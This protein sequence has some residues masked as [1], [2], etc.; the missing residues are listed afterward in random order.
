MANFMRRLAATS[1]LIITFA[2]LISMPIGTLQITPSREQ[3]T[4]ISASSEARE[5]WWNPNWHHR[6]FAELDSQGFAIREGCPIEYTIDLSAANFTGI[7]QNSFR[8]V[9]K[10]T[11]LPTEFNK[12][13]KKLAFVTPEGFS[14]AAPTQ[15]VSVYYDLLANGL[16]QSQRYD[17]NWVSRYREFYDMRNAVTEVNG[18][19]YYNASIYYE[20]GVYYYQGEMVWQAANGTW[21][22]YNGT[23]IEHAYNYSAQNVSQSV[24]VGAMYD[25]LMLDALQTSNSSDSDY[26]IG[27]V[28]ATATAWGAYR[29][30]EGAWV[31]E[32]LQT[33]LYRNSPT[34]K[35]SVRSNVTT[36]ERAWGSA[37]INLNGSIHFNQT[38]LDR[39]NVTEYILNETETDPGEYQQAINNAS[40]ISLVTEAASINVDQIDWSSADILGSSTIDTY[41]VGMKQRMSFIYHAGT[42]EYP[43]G[44]DTVMRIEAVTGNVSGP[45]AHSLVQGSPDAVSIPAATDLELVTVEYTIKRYTGSDELRVVPFVLQTSYLGLHDKQ[46][47]KG[48]TL[49]FLDS[50]A[51]NNILIEVWKETRGSNTLYFCNI[52]VNYNDWWY[53]WDGISPLHGDLPGNFDWFVSYID[54]VQLDQF[55]PAIQDVIDYM[56]GLRPVHVSIKA[57]DSALQIKIMIHEPTNNQLVGGKPVKIV[58]SVTVEGETLNRMY[59][60][61]SFNKNRIPFDRTARILIGYDDNPLQA[62]L[63]STA[64]FDAS[65]INAPI[66]NQT[67]FIEAQDTNGTFVV[68]SACIILSPESTVTFMIAVTTIGIIAGLSIF[69]IITS[70]RIKVKLEKFQRR[71]GWTSF[72]I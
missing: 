3:A 61:F 56:R 13:T 11:E 65:V 55:L 6:F 25:G 39:W 52:S 42:Q 48:A 7:D 60:S 37:L 51:F 34:V 2:G 54:S 32:T 22:Y 8:V 36:S 58:I 68:E 43:L 41:D 9:Y 53:T 49:V 71:R 46:S 4:D 62:H 44:I 14:A 64:T 38:F 5:L 35:Y 28:K 21:Y 24:L 29:N 50:I 72:K 31:K 12:T 33:T 40:R 20:N 69:L 17:P 30:H 67:L 59:Y 16:K 26:V 23:A 47:N 57:H 63:A 27:N 1:I 45:I 66:G 70:P 15:K 19:Y 10:G 18:S